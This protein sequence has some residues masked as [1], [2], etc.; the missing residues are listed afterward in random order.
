MDSS[1]ISVIIGG[2]IALVPTIINIGIDFVKQRQ[3][4]QREMILKQIDLVDKPRIEALREYAYQI[5][6]F[7]SNASIY[8]DDFS[9]NKYIAA[10]ARAAAFVSAKTLKAMN[11]AYPVIMAGWNDNP[12]M[13]TQKKL[14][15]PQIATLMRCLNTEMT[16]RP[17]RYNVPAGSHNKINLKCKLHK[18]KR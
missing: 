18:K 1:L 17:K 9:E 16:L 3:Q 6:A 15:S 11:A 2:S 13:S 4:F 8:G 10:Q 14:E 5:G 12:D 7:L